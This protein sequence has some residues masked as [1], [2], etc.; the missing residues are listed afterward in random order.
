[1]PDD[2]DVHM[3]ASASLTNAQASLK[4]HVSRSA[5]L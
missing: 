5:D 1:M 3:T 2:P 4:L